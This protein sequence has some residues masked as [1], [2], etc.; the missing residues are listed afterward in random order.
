MSTKITATVVAL[1]FAGCLGPFVWVRT[2]PAYSP[3]LHP[4]RPIRVGINQSPPY[5]SIGSSGLYSGLSVDLFRTIAQ[6]KGLNIEFVLAP[7][8]PDAALAKRK[9]D[10][11]PLL[12]DTP[13]RRG[14]VFISKPYLRG[15]YGSLTLEDA[16][17]QKLPDLA[18]NTV[19]FPDTPMTR[20]VI[21]RYGGPI[22]FRPYASA[23]LALADVCTGK[24][25]ALIANT[26]NLQQLMLD[27]P[28]ACKASV[29]R[30]LPMDYSDYS[31]G[32]G[33]APENAA[34]ASAFRQEIDELALDDTIA[35][36]F[37]K[38]LLAPPDE[39]RQL[40]AIARARTNTQ[41]LIAGITFLL[42]TI[43]LV[44]AQNHSLRRT[45][46]ELDEAIL[47]A[48]AA[49]AAKSAFLANMSHEIRTPMN[50]V[51]GMADALLSEGLNPQQRECASI[52]R[53]SGHA[54][55][56]LINDILDFSKIEAGKLALVH[57][58]FSLRKLGE[59]VMS[60]FAGE[61]AGRGI[62]LDLECDE[63]ADVMCRGDQDRLR[64]ILQNLVGNAVKFTSAGVVR[65]SVRAS[66]SAGDLCVRY[67]IFDS[68]VGIGPDQLDKLFQP[69]SQV[70]GS[71]TRRF[72][73]T[74]LGLVI[75]RRL[76]EV[77]GG[78]I[79]YTP[80]VPHGS[81]F[82]FTIR[83]DRCSASEAA[84][85]VV[86]AA[87]ETSPLGLRVLVAEDNKV[88]QMVAGKLLQ[89]L[90]CRCDFA[91][92]GAEAVRMSDET[93]YDVILMD[94]HMPHMDGLAATA[95]IRVAGG[96]QPIIAMTA[97]TLAEDRAACIAA[98]MDAYVSK[99]VTLEELESVLRPFAK[100]LTQPSCA[101]QSSAPECTTTG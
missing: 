70:D 14:K 1:L 68:G 79:G 46:N 28:A 82:W 91:S 80:N 49:S 9:V 67:D 87:C 88:N 101:P 84:S 17:F 77:M 21:G 11:W 6:R 81:R 51:V 44:F 23:Q 50:G 71:T 2:P 38:W 85:P 65:L 31:M 13:S 39:M 62:G 96:K 59:S 19:A 36:L 97:S 100:R 99:P 7:E 24:A 93:G 10:V 95:A 41:A 18:G 60:S 86:E 92:D 64:Q 43:I 30:T 52:I 32:V 56:R 57:T 78:E 54:L 72:G 73:G 83:L 15:H 40:N 74:G 26:R 58:A 35:G 37:A 66:D 53:S 48:N 3:A 42:A 5:S 47:R 33:V 69:F 29:F 20:Y 16:P 25:Q 4:A 98:G 12:T 90:H 55:L 89:R 34:L 61:A 94:C 63:S 45:R 27:R 75:S 76:V 8:G 22:A